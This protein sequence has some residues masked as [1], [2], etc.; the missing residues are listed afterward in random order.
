MNS[1]VEWN[2]IPI[3]VDRQAPFSPFHALLSG[4][5]LGGEVHPAYLDVC[6]S[7]ESFGSCTIYLVH[8]F[9]F[10]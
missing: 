6:N 5:V 2:D 3:R 1:E 7:L 9:A 10:F 4:F 8:C